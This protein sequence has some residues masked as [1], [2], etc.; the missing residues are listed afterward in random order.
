MLN[1]FS[2]ACIIQASF[3][4]SLYESRLTKSCHFFFV[5]AQ[6]HKVEVEQKKLRDIF[7]GWTSWSKKISESFVKI[8]W[9]F[10]DLND[11]LS[12]S[13]NLFYCLVAFYSF[14]FS[15]GTGSNEL[16]PGL[17]GTDAHA[18]TW[19]NQ[20]RKFHA[21]D[22]T[23]FK[24]RFWSELTNYW[25]SNPCL[26]SSFTAVALLALKL[27]IKCSWL[28]WIQTQ[29]LA[30]CLSGLQMQFFYYHLVVPYGPN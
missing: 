2:S 10:G 16:G 15:A 3:A 6:N 25:S 5:P 20:S 13:F 26:H 17:K 19:L 28:C 18:R 30:T 21:L 14:L 1:W 24:A 29:L 22:S 11:F 27:I 7:F 8:F 9:L 12:R 4:A 23:I